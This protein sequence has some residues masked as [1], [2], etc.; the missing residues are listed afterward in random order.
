MA[1]FSYSIFFAIMF[2]AFMAYPLFLIVSDIETRKDAG[3]TALYSVAC[4]TI[5]TI[6]FSQMIAP[7]L[8]FSVGRQLYLIYLIMMSGLF[9]KAAWHMIFLPSDDVDM[10]APSS[11]PAERSVFKSV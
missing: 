6:F 3:F 1:S 10:D 7:Y 11:T 5:G 8:T 9:A 4:W 2:G